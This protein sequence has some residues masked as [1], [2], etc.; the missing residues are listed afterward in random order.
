MLQSQKHLFNL[1]PSV[2]YLNN[3]YRAPQLN[4]AEQA[5]IASIISQRN[6][7]QFK[8][9][10]F[11]DGVEI[12]RSSF[13]KLVNCEPASVALMPSTSYGFSS[14][15]NNIKAKPNSKAIVV[16]DEFPS[17]YFSIARW[18]KE[19]HARV[20]T[21]HPDS[22]ASSKGESWNENLLKAIDFSTSVVLISSIHWMSG[23]KFDLKAIGAKCKAVG[24]IFIVDG[25]QSVGAMPIDVQDC[26]IDALICATYKWLLGPYS[27]AI[28]YIGEKFHQGIPLEESWM[29]R[30]NARDFGKLSEY[31]ENYSAGAARFTVGEASNFVLLP[32]LQASLDQILAWTPEA[33]Q[34]YSK[35][36]NRPLLDFIERIGGHIE[37]ELF[38]A[39]HL[40]APQLPKGINSDRLK[41]ELEENQIFVSARGEYLRISINVFNEQKDIDALMHVIGQQL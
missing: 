9:T 6:P 28:A 25:T 13:G 17:G 32:M 37:P 36:L 16:K 14:V 30:Q 41:K 33:I 5:G 3:A 12:I 23:V 11:F 40:L 34:T 1:D 20:E 38:L 4:A 19:N 26:Q 35:A 27:L 10:D 8:P 18:A 15:L 24:A 31:E 29:N 39:Q 22:V 7:F 21:V 2:H